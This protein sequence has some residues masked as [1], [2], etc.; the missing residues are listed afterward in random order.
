MILSIFGFAGGVG[1]PM[2]TSVNAQLGRRMGSPFVAALINFAIGLGV[3]VMVCGA[4]L[5]HLA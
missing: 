2:Q 1:M 3:L 5:F 4:V